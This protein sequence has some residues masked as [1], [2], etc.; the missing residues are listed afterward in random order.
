MPGQRIANAAAALLASGSI[1][2]GQP[3]PA[4]SSPP[5]PVAASAS[6]VEVLMAPG[7]SPDYVTLP[8]TNCGCR[9]S[10]EN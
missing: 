1:V 8:S 5:E 10:E 2:L 7:N 9:C 6:F 3:L 4:Q